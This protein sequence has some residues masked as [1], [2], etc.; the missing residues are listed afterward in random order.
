MPL[1]SGQLSLADIA[2]EYGGS[3]PH[4]LSE[5]YD[6]GNA[7]GSGEI[8]L[9]ADFQGTSNLFSFSITSNTSN[10]NLRSAAV[11]AGWDQSIPVQATIN[12]GVTITASNNSSTA[13]VIDGSW[14]GLTL[15]NNGTVKGYGG[16]GGNGATGTAQGGA[17]AAGSTAISTSVTMT[18]DNNGS[19]L[20]GG[21]G[22]GGSGA[23]AN[24][25]TTGGS[26]GGGGA[27]GGSGGSR[28]G[29]DYGHLTGVSGSNASGDS[30]GQG[31]QG[32]NTWNHIGGDGGDVGQAGGAG[33]A[34]STAHGGSNGPGGAGGAAG[35]YLSGA[36]NV[37]FDSTGTRTGRSG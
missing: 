11:S 21:G 33:S 8:Q 5:Y 4:K 25:Q 19:L 24:P 18:I 30:G 2:A 20:G 17:G 6:K 27:P 29:G 1:G 9:H 36:S 3:E 16:N 15:V 26:G 37:T 10:L 7:P 28:G 31:G 22:G 12:S 13:L 35:Y 34:G 23:Y 32:G 14:N